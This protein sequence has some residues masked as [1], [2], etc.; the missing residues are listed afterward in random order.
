MLLTILL[1]ATATTIYACRSGPSTEGGG[2]EEQ[3]IS[4]YTCPMH[5]QIHEDHP[6]DC[7]ICHM[8]LVPVYKEGGEPSSENNKR[9]SQKAGP[10]VR[11]D[12]Q[13]QQ[14]IGLTT[15]TVEKMKLTKIIRTS[16]QVAYD[17]KAA[18]A[19]GKNP[20]SSPLMVYAPLFFNEVPLVKPGQNVSL[21]YPATREK[22]VGIVK[23]VEPLIDATSRN[24]LARIEVTDAGG[25][26][27]PGTYLD[28]S[29]EVNLGEG[30][31]VPKSA[32]IDT[33]VRQ[34]VF[35]V[36]KTNR[37]EGR[38][39]TLGTDAEDYQMVLSGL[40]EGEVVATNSLFMIDSEAQLKAAVSG[41]HEH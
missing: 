3:Q 41:T 30:L 15:A 2:S 12:T 37:F 18:M 36:N 1:L 31:S 23:N 28:T 33:G 11:I 38:D 20:S 14:M 39:V 10:A 25:K 21:T 19:Q 9:D 13:R 32:V 16:G 40:D 4:H 27:P 6:G 17:L 26:I 35:V 24:T 7:P 22:F 34:M 8:R 5:P 29:I